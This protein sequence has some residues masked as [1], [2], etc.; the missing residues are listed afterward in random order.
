MRLH[1]QTLNITHSNSAKSSNSYNT[2]LW[3]P[4]RSSLKDKPQ[5]L[6][7]SIKVRELMLTS[8]YPT[9]RGSTSRHLQKLTPIWDRSPSKMST[10]TFSTMIET[11]CLNRIETWT[12]R[13]IAWT[14]S[15]SWL[16]PLIKES[17]MKMRSWWTRWNLRS[18]SKIKTTQSIHSQE[19]IMRG[20]NLSNT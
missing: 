13:D 1:N 6:S 7:H 12:T 17:L 2:I 9:S 18:H 11:G 16:I 3:W 8:S 20:S 5:V 19:G 14:T 10:L 4:S 15:R